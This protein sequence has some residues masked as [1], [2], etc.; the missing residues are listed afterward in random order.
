MPVVKQRRNV[1]YG[2]SEALL[3]V[4]QAPIVSQRAPTTSD[5]AEIG[6]IWIDEPNNDAY[7]LTSIVAN[8]ATWI[9]SGGG[10]GTFTS[11]TVTPGP[12]S[13]T[14]AITLTGVGSAVTIAAGAGIDIDS[15]GGIAINATTGNLTLDSDAA[16]SNIDIGVG[17]AA[18][19]L[20][21]LGTGASSKTI[22][23]GNA[24]GTTGVTITSGSSDIALTTAG[25]SDIVLASTQNV[26][27][28]ADAAVSINVDVG[29][30]SIGTT[31]VDQDVV[32][33]NTTAGS[34]VTINTPANEGLTL[35]AVRVIAGSGSPD[36][37]VTA[38]AGSLFLRT[39]PAGATSRAYI[40]TD[41]VTAWTNITC[42]A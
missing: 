4:P 11:L 25:L 24:T 41:G 38:P 1:G 28:N 26:T 39:D 14:G 8:S 2:L 20:V 7:T 5:K 32:I 12:V 21:N 34:T 15:T 6:T 31:A 19:Q 3:N 36:T 9:G 10:A 40:N 35:G 33:G 22:A 30:I 16:A 29:T 13:L 42:A 23:I 27:I 18:G 17:T 37:V